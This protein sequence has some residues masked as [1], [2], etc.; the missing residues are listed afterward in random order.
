MS[1]LLVWDNISRT[2]ISRWNWTSWKISPPPRLPERGK[3]FLF[4]DSPC[5]RERLFSQALGKTAPPCP[6]NRLRVLMP[7]L[8]WRHCS[9]VLWSKV[10]PVRDWVGLGNQEDV[11]K[12]F[13][14]QKYPWELKETF[15]STMPGISRAFST[16][17]AVFVMTSGF[18]GKMECYLT[19]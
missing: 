11:F 9:S 10:V 12:S 17:L 8:S 19:T 4:S 1:S 5:T 14:S 2:T 6:Y 13:S 3:G 18:F 16:H 7:A 15:K